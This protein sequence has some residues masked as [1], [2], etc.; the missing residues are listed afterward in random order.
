MNKYFIQ[1]EDDEATEEDSFDSKTKNDA[2]GDYQ[3]DGYVIEVNTTIALTPASTIQ[4]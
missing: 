2:N 4:E 3:F 1:M